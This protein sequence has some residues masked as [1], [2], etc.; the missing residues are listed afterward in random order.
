[1]GAGEQGAQQR[2]EDAGEERGAQNPLGL[3]NPE[4]PWLASQ[5][6]SLPAAENGQ[7]MRGRMA[8]AVASP[9]GWGLGA[10][11]EDTGH[12]GLRGAQH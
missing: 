2:P 10:E 6:H 4:S 5:L 8:A 12:A 1:M 11:A 7:E 3:H 9:Q